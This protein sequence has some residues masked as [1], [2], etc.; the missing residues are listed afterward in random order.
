MLPLG[1]SR[2]CPSGTPAFI[3]KSKCS[4]SSSSFTHAPKRR[5]RSPRKVLMR[6]SVPKSPVQLTV[7]L[8]SCAASFQLAAVKRVL[9]ANACTFCLT[10]A[11][12][13]PNPHATP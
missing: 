12:P 5:R 9:C 1:L 2:C 10:P 3:W 13:E 4:A 7:L 8:K 11:F 6:H